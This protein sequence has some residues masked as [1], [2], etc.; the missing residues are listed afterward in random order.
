MLELTCVHLGHDI[1]S[2]GT[3]FS[4]TAESFLAKDWT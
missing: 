1:G 3:Q 2:A 4:K